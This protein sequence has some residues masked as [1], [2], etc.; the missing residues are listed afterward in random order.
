[1]RGKAAGTCSSSHHV[2]HPPSHL[3]TGNPRKFSGGVGDQHQQTVAYVRGWIFGDFL[4]KILNLVTEANFY[5]SI[6]FLACISIDRFLV[7]VHAH[8][9]P[10]NVQRRCS[11]LLCA[12]VWALGCALALPALFHVAHPSDDS[13]EWICTETFD[14]GSSVV[15]RLASRG[16]RHIFGFVAPLAIMIVCYTIT[17]ARLLHTRGFQK[18]KAMRVIISV[19]VA[20]LLCWTPYHVTLVADTLLRTKLVPY[21]CAMRRSV[22]LALGLTKD[23][24]LTHSCIN[25][26]LYAFVGEKFRKKMTRFVQRKLRKERMSG[27]RFSRSTSLTS[28]GSATVF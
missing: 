2:C 15:W 6:I 23:L 25:P 8:E 10:R 20:F 4:C 13:E 18:Y 22:S 3:C 24:A 14:I 21:D 12:A 26:F 28:E 11:R 27:S 9:G 17:I 7:I 1:M 5:T 19:V 16:L